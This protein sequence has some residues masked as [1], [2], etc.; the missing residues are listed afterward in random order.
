MLRLETEFVVNDL[1]FSKYD[2]K[3]LLGITADTF[4][5]K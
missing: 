3:G 1:A 4:E 2:D 5:T